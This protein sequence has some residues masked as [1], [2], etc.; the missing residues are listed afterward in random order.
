MTL[1]AS[2]IYDMETQSPS[3]DYCAE[4]ACQQA[5]LLENKGT[6]EEARQALGLFWSRLGERPQLKGLAPS[7]AA[8]VLLRAGAHPDA[9]RRH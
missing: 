6:Y 8:E 1:P 4:C 2:L 7:V 9:T 5:K 3:L